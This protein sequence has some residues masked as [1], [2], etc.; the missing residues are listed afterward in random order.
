[1]EQSTSSRQMEK[2]RTY[3]RL[4]ISSNNAFASFRGLAYFIEE[5]TRAV[6]VVVA[7]I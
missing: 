5:G 1:M 6:E 3:G 4:S 2:A 7:I